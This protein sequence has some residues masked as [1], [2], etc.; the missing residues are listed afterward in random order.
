MTPET[1]ALYCSECG[2]PVSTDELVRFGDRTICSGCKNAYAQKLREG[3]APAGA[4]RY[5]G[6]WWR[7]LAVC[8]DAIILAI[9]MGVL[10][11]VLFAVV[12][13]SMTR[14]APNPNATPAEVFGA[15]APMFG[16]IGLAWLINIVVGCTYETFFIVKF[17]ATPG[18]MAVG[19][20]F[21]KML[22][23]MILAIGYIMAGFDSEK[24]ALHDMMCDTR[25]FKTRG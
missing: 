2:R 15:L 8:I 16:A 19:R 12:G 14:V 5:G 20:H 10:Q 21:A 13:V 22:S 6:F 25:V 9:P 23:G 7:F 1:Q 18:K 4:V 17:A 11:G 3:A 24:R